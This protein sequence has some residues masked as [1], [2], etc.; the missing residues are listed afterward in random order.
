MN[1][2]NS[3]FI[4]DLLVN[5]KLAIHKKWAQRRIMTFSRSHIFGQA[6]QMSTERL[7]EGHMLQ[8]M[9]QRLLLTSALSSQEMS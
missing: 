8:R 6:H 5:G 3:L 7:A 4:Y 2:T 9:K 1:Y